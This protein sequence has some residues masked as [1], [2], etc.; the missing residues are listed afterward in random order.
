MAP[1]E[2]R[3]RSYWG[4]RTREGVA[5]ARDESHKRA[6]QGTPRCRSR[7]YCGVGKMA[8]RMASGWAC[9]G[10]T[11]SERGACGVLIEPPRMRGGVGGAEQVCVTTLSALST[12]IFLC[13]S[14]SLTDT[15]TL[16]FTPPENGEAVSRRR[17]RRPSG[18]S[19]SSFTTG[20]PPGVCRRA[21]PPALTL[22]LT[23]AGAVL[24]QF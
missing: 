20:A 11:D 18:S 22:P 3:V 15:A 13:V 17:R 2:R 10:M 12:L 4:R 7:Q 6:V 1:R 14:W 21:A 16:F 5:R 24:E 8:R 19:T 9:W 23:F